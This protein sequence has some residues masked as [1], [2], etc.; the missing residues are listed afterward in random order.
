VSQRAGHNSLKRHR[1]SQRHCVGISTSPTQERAFCTGFFYYYAGKEP[2]MSDLLQEYCDSRG[3]ALRVDSHAGLIRGI[4]ILGPHS[5]N[6]REYLPEALAR[7]VGMY[8]G[9]KVNVNHPK[10]HPLAPRDYQ[11]RI[12]IIR[13]VQ[14]RPG[15]G[16]FADF[17]FN[18]KHFLSEQLMWDAQHAPENV[19][20]SH[21][22]QAQTRRQ[23]ETTLVEQILQVHSV[24]LV[25]DPATTRGLYEQF[26]AADESYGDTLNI[27]SDQPAFQ[28]TSE[29]NESSN[30]AVAEQLTV[31]GNELDSFRKL[32]QEQAAEISK[33]HL[34]I[35]QLQ[36]KEAVEQRRSTVRSLLAEYQL[37]DP[38]SADVTAKT[39]VSEAFLQSLLKAPD[40]PTMR[41]LIEDRARLLENINAFNGSTRAMR[42][43]ISRDQILLTQQKADDAKSFVRAITL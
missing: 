22:V 15:E 12:G 20:F 43:P 16:L 41:R 40:E 4:K 10:G 27:P 39:I 21:N 30:A 24:D 31:S 35:E 23:G 26:P 34:E 19:G 3:L 2:S 32:C 5:R 25:A 17:H 13:N 7:A 38:D 11:E 18:P 33:L 37:P 1:T 29:I 28:T 42:R 8:E 6:G 9:A 36:A 14:H